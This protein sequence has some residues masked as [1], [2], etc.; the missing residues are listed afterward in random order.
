MIEAAGIADNTC[1]VDIGGGRSRLIDALVAKRLT[2]LAVLDI[3]HE[4]LDQARR[5]LGAVSTAVT[6]IEAD[7]TGS[8]SLPPVDIWHDR[9]VFHFL[10]EADDRR[11]Y[12]AHLHETVKAGGSAVIATFSPDGPE[13]CSGLPVARYSPEALATELGSAFTL[14]ESRLYG[15]TTPSGAVQ[16]FQ[17][18]RFR[19]IG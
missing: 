8:W 18:S 16:A 17:Y 19:R 14:I 13:K 6:W 10:T 4:A 5:R 11:R 12:V 3:S 7:V 9:A 2:C 1:I 15:H